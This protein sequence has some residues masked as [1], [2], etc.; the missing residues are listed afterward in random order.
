MRISLPGNLLLSGEYAVLEQGEPGVALAVDRTFHLESKSSLRWSIRSVYPQHESIWEAGRDGFLDTII[1]ALEQAFPGARPHEVTLDSRELYHQG[2]KLGL[3]SSACTVTALTALFI[4][5]HH[6]EQIP[7]P[8]SIAKTAVH[9]HRL[10]QK[11]RGSGYDV[12]T[13][14]MGGMGIFLGGTYPAW[15]PINA[16]HIDLKLFR[17]EQ[18]VSSSLAIDKWKT[19]KESFP[20]RWEQYRRYNREITTLARNASWQEYL[21]R[22]RA[23]GIS[24]GQ[25]I[26]LSAEITPPAGLPLL[27]T[28]ALG[29]GN[30]IGLCWDSP[31]ADYPDE[32]I[33][34][35]I[36]EAGLIWGL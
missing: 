7:E 21:S 35:T 4:Y 14:L 18:P 20:G 1:P 2:R 6:G 19:F 31:A 34:A 12:M 3:G 28:K 33:A 17:G 8:A 36:S 13:S 23:W 27:Q 30:E 16:P 32:L 22:A 9:I 25:D 26:G 15:E 24:L 11:G 10:A 29:A 5:S